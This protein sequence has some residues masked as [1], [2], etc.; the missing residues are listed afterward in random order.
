MAQEITAKDRLRA[1]EYVQELI[2]VYEAGLASMRA[3]RDAPD[4]SHSDR[5]IFDNFIA[6][7]REAVERLRVVQAVVVDASRRRTRRRRTTGE[8]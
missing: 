6:S 1:M 3:Q 5:R 7:H 4:V 8:A 2:D